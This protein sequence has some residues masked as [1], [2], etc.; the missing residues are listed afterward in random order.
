MLHLQHTAK[1]VC[2]GR[3][4]RKW[5]VGAY[6]TMQPLPF[7]EAPGRQHKHAFEDLASVTDHREPYRTSLCKASSLTEV[8]Q[9]QPCVCG[10]PNVQAH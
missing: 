10:K 4:S 7:V 8:C 2:Q 1:S 9:S 5:H 3:K 6:L